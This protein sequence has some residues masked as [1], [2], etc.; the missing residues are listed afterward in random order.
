MLYYL[1]FSL[2]SFSLYLFKCL[3]MLLSFLHL[4]TVYHSQAFYSFVSLHL[5][6][7]FFLLL[8]E[9]IHRI[10]L[11]ESHYSHT[12][13]GNIFAILVSSSFKKKERNNR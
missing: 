6:F 13:T 12:I 2:I 11:Q 3:L 1:D 8:T 4:D 5:F 10:K 9:N 7:F